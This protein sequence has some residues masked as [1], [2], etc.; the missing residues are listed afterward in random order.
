M[1]FFCR[2]GDPED[3][4]QIWAWQPRIPMQPTGVLGILRK[5]MGAFRRIEPLPL[6]KFSKVFQ[7]YP[8]RGCFTPA[9]TCSTMND[10]GEDPYL[11]ALHSTYLGALS[12]HTQVHCPPHTQVH[13]PT[14]SQARTTGISLNSRKFTTSK[15]SK[16]AGTVP[17]KIGAPPATLPAKAFAGTRFCW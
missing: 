16:S 13:S 5:T 12:P 10:P 6:W 14:C 11:G 1:E 17:A 8:Q 9:G 7:L 2:I 3:F 15:T 4:L